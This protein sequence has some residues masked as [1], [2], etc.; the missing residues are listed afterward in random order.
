MTTRRSTRL[1]RSQAFGALASSGMGVVAGYASGLLL[2]PALD[3]DFQTRFVLMMGVIAA[4]FSVLHGAMTWLAFKGLGG[5]L[6]NEALTQSAPARN[7]R[8]RAIMLGADG[9]SWSVSIAMLAMVGVML[10][11]T[12]PQ[13]E[14]PPLIKALS[15]VVVVASWLDVTVT[16]ASYYARLDRF[17]SALRFPD[18]HVRRFG[19]YLYLALATQATFGT[20]D[21]EVTRPYMRRALMGQA[22]LAFFINTVIVAILVSLVIGP[23]A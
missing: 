4:T 23:S 15:V 11:L 13:V 6:L 9:P 12:L 16:Y 8:F 14:I 5:D 1:L 7:T 18:E 10:V 20:T 2:A 19:D 22:L 17:R 3:L 21:V